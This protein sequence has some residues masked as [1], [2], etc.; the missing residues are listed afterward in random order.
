MFPRRPTGQAETVHF[1]KV[2]FCLI[3]VGSRDGRCDDGGPW[4][5]Q[6]SE[7]CDGCTSC[8]AP[9]SMADTEEVL[10]IIAVMLLARRRVEIA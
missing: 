2:C 5:L 4:A 9:K 7:T 10:V 8:R 1:V 3:I 6:V